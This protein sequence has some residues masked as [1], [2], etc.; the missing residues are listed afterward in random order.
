MPRNL[1][2]H[3]TRAYEA[4]ADRGFRV[5]EIF[6]DHIFPYRIPEYVQYHYQRN[7]ISHGCR[8][9]YSVGWSEFGLASVRNGRRGIEFSL[10]AISSIR[11]SRIASPTRRASSW[12]SAS[13][14]GK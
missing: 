1:Y 6:V 13:P 10:G 8:T 5:T 12:E 2:V 7:G 11:V 14:K 9:R 3:K 4:L